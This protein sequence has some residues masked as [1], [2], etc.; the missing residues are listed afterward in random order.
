MKAF[1]IT[2][3]NCDLFLNEGGVLFGYHETGEKWLVTKEQ[4]GYNEFVVLRGLV[5][6]DYHRMDL[7]VKKIAASVRQLMEESSSREELGWLSSLELVTSDE[8]NH[9]EGRQALV[10]ALSHAFSAYSIP[11]LITQDD[12]DLYTNGKEC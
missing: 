7:P 10:D 2:A 4:Q 12:I 5:F 9:Y 11:W 1:L 8:W 3:S 6:D